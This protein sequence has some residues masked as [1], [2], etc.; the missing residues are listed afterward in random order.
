[1]AKKNIRFDLPIQLG[2]HIL[3]LAKVR[4][5]QS[6]YDCLEKYCDVKDFEYLEMDM[7]SA[8][9]SMSA[10][11]L[12]EMVLPEK[13]QLLHHEKMGLCR[14]FD[15]TSEDGFFPRECCKKHKAY[16]KRTP[17]L[18]KV[19]AQGKAMIALCSKTYILK[20]HNDKVKFS[21]KG[22]NK[23][24]L[25]KPFQSYQQVLHTGQ[26]KYSTNQGFRS[27]DITIYSTSQKNFAV[28]RPSPADRSEP[29]IAACRLSL[30][31][32]GS[33]RLR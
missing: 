16:D 30:V 20:K 28:G 33:G 14:D 17:G 23:A 29:L 10:K 18:F 19:E 24:S 26:T 5:L 6:R 1:M 25:I 13:R 27:R 8:Y 22:L 15:Y 4:M 21:S 3:Q 11:T 31:T 2:Y 12:E 7:D 32:A 9:I